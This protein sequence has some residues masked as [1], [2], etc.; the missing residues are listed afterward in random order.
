MLLGGD[1]LAICSNSEHVEN[2]IQQSHLTEVEYNPRF[3]LN[4]KGR[5]TSE[6]PQGIPATPQSEPSLDI[7]KKNTSDKDKLGK[8]KDWA[9]NLSIEYVLLCIVGPHIFRCSER[10]T[11]GLVSKKNNSNCNQRS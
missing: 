7:Q 2:L 3:Q 9:S 10:D 11:C 6:D 8:S 5:H 4:E 1:V